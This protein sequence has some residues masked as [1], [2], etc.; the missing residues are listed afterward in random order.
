MSADQN[1]QIGIQGGAGSVYLRND[2]IKQNGNFENL[3]E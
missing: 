1:K 3:Q 2:F